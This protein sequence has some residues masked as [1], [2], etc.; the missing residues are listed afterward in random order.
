MRSSFAFYQNIPL[1]ILYYQRKIVILQKNKECNMAKHP[2]WKKEYWLLL[3]QLYQQKPMGVKPLYSKGMVDLSLEL[4]I[5]PEFLHR[6]MFKLR[7]VTPHITRLWDKY[8]NNPRKLSHDIQLLKK[9]DGCGNA[10]SFYEGVEVKESF[11]HDWEPLETEPSLTPVKLIIILDLY[12]QLTPITMVPETPEIID[13]AKLIKTTPQVIA[14]AMTMFQTCDPYLN[15][16]ENCNSK[17]AKACHEIW[18]RYGN[19]NPDNL[20]KLAIELKEYFV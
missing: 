7:M 3:L 8:A 19:G 1:F 17:L 15:K 5:Q 14:E 12:F 9:M 4:H 2:L 13:L 16:G 20:Y 6:Q 18:Q 11:E 10:A